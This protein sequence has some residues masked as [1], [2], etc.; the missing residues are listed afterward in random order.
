MKLWLDAQLPPLLARWIN[1]QRWALQA[2][3][4]R[5]VGMRDAS[6][7]EIFRAARNAGV[8]VMT[9]D[10]DF[11]RL[12][13]EQGPPT[14]GDLAASGQQQQRCLAEGSGNDLAPCDGTT[15]GRGA[16]GRDPSEPVRRRLIQR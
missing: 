2:I 8:V 13:D 16:L 12:L 6:D 11:M 15:Q 7:P 3:A 5:D 1:E 4:V 14:P 9:K 10:R